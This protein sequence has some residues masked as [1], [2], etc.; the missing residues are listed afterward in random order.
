MTDNA[1]SKKL[2]LDLSHHFSYTTAARK[3]SQIKDFYKYFA[4]PGIANL[5]GGMFMLIEYTHTWQAFSV[6]RL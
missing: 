1:G 3:G 4:I 6:W 2:P 5:A